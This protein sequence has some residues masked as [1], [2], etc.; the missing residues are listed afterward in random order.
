[1]REPRADSRRSGPDEG[2]DVCAYEGCR[3]RV[4]L[5]AQLPLSGTQEAGP[6]KTEM[7]KQARALES[8]VRSYRSH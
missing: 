5:L 3:H 4:Q 6:K 2:M 1:M 7:A 8:N